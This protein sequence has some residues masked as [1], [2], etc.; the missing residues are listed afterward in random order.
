MAG[1]T[2]GA[3]LTFQVTFE[4]ADY[5]DNAPVTAVVTGRYVTNYLS[6]AEP[7]FLRIFDKTDNS[8]KRYFPFTDSVVGRSYV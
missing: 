2:T 5:S 1:A 7:T 3:P 8:W 4:F 6:K